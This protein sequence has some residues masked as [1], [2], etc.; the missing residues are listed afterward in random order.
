MCTRFL[1]FAISAL[2]APSGVIPT[3]PWPFYKDYVCLLLIYSPST[4]LSSDPL[5]LF[6]R[7]HGVIPITNP[8]AQRPH[9]LGAR[10]GILEKIKV[11]GTSNNGTVRI[12]DVVAGKQVGALT[13]HKSR[14][15]GLDVSIDGRR[16]VSGAENGKIIIWDAQTKK[17]IRHLFKHTMRVICGRFFPDVRTLASALSDS[18]LKIWNAETGKLVF[19]IDDHQDGVLTVAYSPN[20]TKIASGSD[21]QTVRIWNAA[22][23]KHRR[24]I[25]ACNDGQIYF[26]SAPTGAQLGSPLPAHS[27][28]INLLVIPPDGELIASASV[29]HTARLWSTSTRKPFGHMLQH[30]SGVSTVACSP[31]GQLVATGGTIFLWDI[32]Q[33][34]ITMTNTLS[35]SFVTPVSHITSNLDQVMNSSLVLT[36]A[37]LM[38]V[39]VKVSGWLQSSVI[40]ASVFHVNA[41]RGN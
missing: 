12:W 9:S 22:T 4:D 40:G 13:G 38:Q 5:P 37:Y 33:A 35:P 7:L 26:W 31:D 28:K 10:S 29:D 14:T 17:K 8:I 32:S 36:S 20:R 34:I 18:T 25:S 15:F 41:R 39:V 30:A 23:G 3:G 27:N 11:M 19:N 16:I 21:D 2:S 6:Q 24:L 1:A